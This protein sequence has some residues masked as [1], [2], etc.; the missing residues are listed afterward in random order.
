ME[1]LAQAPSIETEPRLG[2]ELA[3]AILALSELGTDE[4]LSALLELAQRGYACAWLDDLFAQH[5]ARREA[6]Q[7]F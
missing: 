6:Q 5:L 1:V 3:E 4:D 7:G 2:P